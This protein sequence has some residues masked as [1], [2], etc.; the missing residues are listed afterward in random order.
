MEKSY[1]EKL[2]DPRWKAIRKQVFERDGYCCVCCHN[3]GLPIHCHHLK[4]ER[5]KEPWES[6]LLD[7]V[8]VCKY[9]HEDIHNGIEKIIRINFTPLQREIY[10]NFHEDE[11]I[12]ANEMV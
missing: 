11:I 12:I 3:I 9:C 5:G 1:S 6:S 2:E 8:T 10:L 4:Y 7:L